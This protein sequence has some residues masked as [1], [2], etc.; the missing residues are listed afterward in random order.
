[1]KL[2]P[3]L[4]ELGRTHHVWVHEVVRSLLVPHR[5]LVWKEFTT[6]R[7][8]LLQHFQLTLHLEILTI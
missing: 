3:L 4:D 7:V 8:H 6:L 2:S 5:H 1:M